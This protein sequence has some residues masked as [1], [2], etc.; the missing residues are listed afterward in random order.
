M[1]KCSHCQVQKP[2]D[3]F[4]IYR[5]AKDGRHSWC[6]IC[7]NKK[8]RE[9]RKNNP[10][11]WQK[12]REKNFIKWRETLGVDPSIRLRAKSGEGYVNRW[13]YLSYRKKGHPCADKNSRVQASHLVIYE[14]TG[15]LLKKGETVH[16]KN[17]DPLDNRLENLEIWHSGHPFGQRLEDKIAWCKEF[18]EEYGYK[19]DKMEV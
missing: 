14:N 17:G 9:Y 1:K 10:T 16:H 3:E 8:N 6:R 12:Q 13:G 7:F 11:I 2:L 15:R 18:L 5:R 4:C 19:V